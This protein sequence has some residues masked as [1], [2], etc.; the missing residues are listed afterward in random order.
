MHV[1]PPPYLPFLDPHKGRP[2]G[3]FALDPVDWIEID[4]AYRPQMAYR[5]QLIAERPDEVALALPEADEPVAELT[6]MVVAH[7]AALPGGGFLPLTG[8]LR[9]P[10]GVTVIATGRP[11]ALGRFAQEDWLI[12]QRSSDAAEYMLTAGNL[13]FPSHWRLE[14]KLG[15][16]LT[17]I[18]DPVPGYGEDLARRVNRVFDALHAD[19]PL[20]RLNWSVVE[21]GELRL[22]GSRA[23]RGR[24]GPGAPD[25]AF[26]LRVER[27][28]LRRLPRSG[29]VVF[30]VKT[31]VSPLSY[32]PQEALAP[33]RERLSA[34]PGALVDYKGGAGFRRAVLALLDD[35]IAAPRRLAP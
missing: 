13:C 28:T 34:M 22:A 29:A 8:S 11:G 18:H 7:L 3:L 32:L 20:Q 12:L 4:A 17:P 23:E 25:E 33:L 24:A 31:Y 6:E 5:D 9:R 2:P 10:D 14:D 35:R 27:Q 1:A 19:R 21:E 26:F 15:K 16:P 30:G